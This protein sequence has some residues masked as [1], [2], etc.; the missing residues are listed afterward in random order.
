GKIPELR[1]VIVATD[2]TIAMESTLD[3]SINRLFGEG[4]MSREKTAAPPS[5]TQASATPVSPRA[6]LSGDQ[7]ALIEQALQSYK[8]AEQ[9]QRNGDWAQYGEEQKRLGQVLEKLKAAQQK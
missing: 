5:D 8:R 9:A 7:Q 6:P 4:T 1:R 2:K 3:E